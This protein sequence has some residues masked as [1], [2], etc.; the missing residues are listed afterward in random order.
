[1]LRGSALVPTAL[2]MGYDDGLRQQWR[3]GRRYRARPRRH[4]D[5]AKPR[6]NDN[7]H[8]KGKTERDSVR[9]I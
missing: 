7:G 6:W 9:Q 8:G 4:D 3:W 2:L 1:M 5:D